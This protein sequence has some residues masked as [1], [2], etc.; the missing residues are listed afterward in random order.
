M[1]VTLAVLADY[2]NVTGDGK[3]NILGIFDRM[4]VASL[5]AVHPQMNLVLR[6]E[7]HSSE[8]DRSHPVEIRLHDPDGQTIF[9][10]KGEILPQ[11]EPGQTIST[12]QILTLNNLQLSKTGDYTFIVFVNNDLKAEIPLLVEFGGLD[13]GPPMPPSV[14]PLH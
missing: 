4:N 9:E 11:G 14:G 1:H 5:P 10:V 6:I 8:R 13:G 2:A 3:L 12:N 7:A